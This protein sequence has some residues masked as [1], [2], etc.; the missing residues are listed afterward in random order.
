MSNS[1][2]WEDKINSPELEA[3]FQQFGLK[4][5]L[6]AEQINQIRDRINFLLLNSTSESDKIIDDKGFEI[7]NGIFKANPDTVWN[8]N[9]QQ[10]SNTSLV[11]IPIALAAAGMKVFYRIV[12][13]TSNTFELIVGEESDTSPAVPNKDVDQLDYTIVLVD[14]ASIGTPT[15]PMVGG[16]YIKKVFSDTYVFNGSG[17]LV[18]IPLLPNGKS[19]ISLTNPGLTSISGF[20]FTLL[21]SG[22]EYPYEGKSIYL[23]NLTGNA[24]EIKH[25]DIAG[26]EFPILLKNEISLIIPDK[27]IV[28]LRFKNVEVEEV[29]RSWESQDL[30]N[31]IDNGGYWSSSD[32]N[33]YL[34]VT[35]ENFIYS[36]SDTAN[37]FVSSIYLD[38][39]GFAIISSTVKNTSLG[40]KF[41][42]S[43]GTISGGFLNLMS[44]V[45]SY[46][47]ALLRRNRIF[48]TRNAIK[49]SSNP[50]QADIGVNITTDNLTSDI[51]IQ[52]GESGIVATRGWV[53]QQ[54]VLG[55]V[56]V[57]LDSTLK[58]YFY[59]P[60]NIKINSITNI[61]GTPTLT[62]LQDA[63]SY[64]LGEPINQG[65]LIT[66][67]SDSEGV[68]NLNISY[69]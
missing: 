68:V 31:V 69:E 58:N 28:F 38:K 43:S 59:A 20:D 4:Y 55:V 65:A 33:A 1:L 23:Q 47:D 2:D 56:T 8:I 42:N 66:I 34:E 64:D 3:W 51:N 26:I 19:F 15:V 24:V 30:K 36:A 14:E 18:S 46:A 39:D 61:K 41:R 7:E 45:K 62:I 60:E 37:D 16:E 50:N 48:F 17:A 22:S 29:F 53:N 21:T 35:N 67:N 10:Y 32:N 11:G 54:S 27:E 5:Y 25:N 57:E 44:D 40:V 6:N 49:I 52:F 9:G 13:N 63:N 12:L